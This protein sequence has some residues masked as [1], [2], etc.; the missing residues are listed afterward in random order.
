MP[1]TRILDINLL[2]MEYPFTRQPYLHLPE[3]DIGIVDF[4][5]VKVLAIPLFI[6]E[7]YERL[8]VIGWVGALLV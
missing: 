4:M 7:V 8:H 1:T 6:C 3:V 5:E 2:I